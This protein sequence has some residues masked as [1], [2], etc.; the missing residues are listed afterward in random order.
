MIVVTGA[1][2]QL[3]RAIIEKLV[4]RV[5]ILYV[6]KSLELLFYFG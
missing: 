5:C 1:T 2:G 6:I 3:G 4:E